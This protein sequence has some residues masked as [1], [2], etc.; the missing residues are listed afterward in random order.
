MRTILF[1]IVVIAGL[2]WVGIAPAE[3]APLPMLGMSESNVQVAPVD[4]VGYRRRYYR[5]YGY[6]YVAPYAYYPPAYYYPPVYSY[7]PAYRYPYNGYRYYQPYY[8]PY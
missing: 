6:G 7:Y 5:R 8:A 3:A 2:V 1:S 4:E